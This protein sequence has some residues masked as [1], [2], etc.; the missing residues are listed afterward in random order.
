MLVAFFLFQIIEAQET[1]KQSNDSIYEYKDVE[2]KPDFNGGTEG[3]YKFIAKNFKSPE[4]E[5]LNGKIIA[6]FIIEKDGTVDDVKI[7]QDVGFGSA[8]EIIKVLSKCPKW[9]PAN[10]NGIPVRVYFQLPITI[11]SADKYS[12]KSK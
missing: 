12:K 7:L 10:I 1:S 3:F 9:I 11:K 2:V 5:G 6:T 4:Q 8:D